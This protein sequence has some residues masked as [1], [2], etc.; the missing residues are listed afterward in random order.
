MSELVRRRPRDARVVGCQPKGVMQVSGDD[1]A[2]LGA[3]GAM[4]TFDN[5]IDI[6]AA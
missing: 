3:N 4:P 6:V 5:L 2:N 1:G